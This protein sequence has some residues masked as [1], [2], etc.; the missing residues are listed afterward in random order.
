MYIQNRVNEDGTKHK[1]L[2]FEVRDDQNDYLSSDVATNTKLYDPNDGKAMT[3][4]KWRA[5]AMNLDW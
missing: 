3:S 1:R 2:F 5:R 4:K